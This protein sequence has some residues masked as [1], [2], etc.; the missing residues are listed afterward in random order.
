MLGCQKETETEIKEAPTGQ[1]WDTLCMNKNFDF[2]NYKYKT[3]K[4]P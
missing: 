2:N 4:N 3:N 1:I